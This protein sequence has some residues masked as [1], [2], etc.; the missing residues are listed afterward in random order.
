[1]EAALSRMRCGETSKANIEAQY[2]VDIHHTDV[3]VAEF[4]EELKI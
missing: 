2:K 4:N 3:K 1:M